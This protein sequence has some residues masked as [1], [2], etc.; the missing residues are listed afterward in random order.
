[1]LKIIA[2]I[3][4]V[5]HGIIHLIGFV[6]G[7]G[8]QDVPSI[9][10]NISPFMGKL[11][12]I[13]CVL[14]LLVALFYALETSLWFWLGVPAF[15]LSTFLVFSVWKD[16]YAGLLTNFIFFA[17]LF[18]HYEANQFEGKFEQDIKA[19]I[20]RSLSSK[21]KIIQEEDLAHLPEPVQYYL[22][23][24][25]VVGKAQARNVAIQFDAEMRSPEQDWFKMATRQVNFIDQY[26]RF[27]FLEANLNYLPVAGY[28]RYAEEATMDIRA[29]S[30]MT[31]AGYGDSGKGAFYKAE[32][33]TFLNDLCLFAPAALIDKRLKWESIDKET[34]KVSL[35]NFGIKVSA[36][37][38]FDAQGKLANFV[39]DD[40]YDVNRKAFFRFSTPV[41]DFKDFGGYR[42]PSYGEAIW[43]YPEGK[44]TYGKFRLKHLEYN[45]K[46]AA[47]R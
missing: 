11:W 45:L 10:K 38:Y 23:Y 13:A 7:S 9:R 4:I 3:F 33:V 20:T 44:F 18:Q 47:F 27:F 12:L 35:E 41:K 8:I 46:E 17:M 29:L 37:L 39:S 21:P 24:V 26:E 6:K 34:V 32:T 2:I 5:L 31:L 30:M 1:M 22:R 16:A 15:L 40:R 28:H 25:G 42:L 43:H 14:F 19:G 36:K